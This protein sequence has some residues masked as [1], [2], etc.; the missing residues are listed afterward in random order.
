MV[1]LIYRLYN[2]QT[3]RGERVIRDRSNSLEIYNDK[4]LIE[5]FWFCRR[6]LFELI[7]ELSPDLQFVSYH[8]AELSPASQLLIARFYA[9]SAFQITVWDVKTTTAVFL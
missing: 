7:E 8:N 1:H 6:D 5:R 4:E 3:F 2:K 9:D